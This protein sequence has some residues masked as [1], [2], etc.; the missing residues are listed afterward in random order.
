ME[1]G[2]MYSW[3]KDESGK[4]TTDICCNISIVSSETKEKLLPNTLHELGHVIL[5]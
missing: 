2:T 1:C 3:Y 5:E 4:Y